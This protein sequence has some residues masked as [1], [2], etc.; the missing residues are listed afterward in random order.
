MGYDYAPVAV[1]TAVI[2]LP[3]AVRSGCAGRPV[4][5]ISPVAALGSAAVAGPRVAVAG[6]PDLPV[7]LIGVVTVAGGTF[8]DPKLPLRAIALIRTPLQQPSRSS[9]PRYC[10]RRRPLPCR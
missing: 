6:H 2:D 7:R 1:G 3:E 10:S 8:R 4:V 5:A 9:S